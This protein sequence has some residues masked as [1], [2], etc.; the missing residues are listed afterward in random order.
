MKSLTQAD[1]GGREEKARLPAWNFIKPA[2]LGT[3]H[4][5]MISGRLMNNFVN[6]SFFIIKKAT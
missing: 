3:R 1:N 5:K 6:P 4:S 2:G